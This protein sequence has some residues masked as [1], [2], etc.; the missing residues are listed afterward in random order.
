MINKETISEWRDNVIENLNFAT[1]DFLL[2][3]IEKE[4]LLSL[5]NL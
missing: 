4:I 5:Q 3:D 1:F 2:K